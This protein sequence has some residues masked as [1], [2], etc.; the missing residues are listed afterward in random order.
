MSLV[1]NI[2]SGSILNNILLPADMNN[3]TGAGIFASFPTS[4][5]PSTATLV[6][7][8][9]LGTACLLLIILAVTDKKYNIAAKSVISF[10]ECDT[11]Y[12]NM[13]VPTGMIPLLIGLGLSAIHFSLATNSGCAVNPARDFAP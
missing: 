1:T 3:L 5:H 8:Q 2:M 6:F 10:H 11:F 7:D 12:R 9:A 4:E 13:K